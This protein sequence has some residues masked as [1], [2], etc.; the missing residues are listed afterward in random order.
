MSEQLRRCS[1]SEYALSQDRPCMSSLKTLIIDINWPLFF[2]CLHGTAL[3]RLLDRNFSCDLPH[4]PQY[5]F[6]SKVY[7]LCFSG[8]YIQL[9]GR[10][11]FLEFRAAPAPCRPGSSWTSL[12]LCLKFF[13]SFCRRCVSQ[14]CSRPPCMINLVSRPPY[15]ERF[16][17]PSRSLACTTSYADRVIAVA[18]YSKW[19]VTLKDA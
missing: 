15:G 3:A 12:V 19:P 11:P 4:I 7:P 8:I 10:N 14:C 16:M 9:N 13:I 2:T 17:P 18:G 1:V 6:I 5:H